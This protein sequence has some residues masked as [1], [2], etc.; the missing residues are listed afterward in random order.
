MSV[1]GFGV[2]TSELE[3]FFTSNG[4]T[5]KS[6]FVGVF[7]ADK[8][9]ENFIKFL[10]DLKGKETR[11]PF[12][13]ASTDPEKKLGV[14]W[15]S[16]LDTEE[17]DTL[18]L[19]DS[20]GSHGLL[21]FIVEN[22]LSTFNKLIPGQF[23]QIFKK[24]NKITLLK[25][26]FIFWKYE[27]HKEKELNKLFDTARHF[28]FGKYKGVKNTVKVVTVDD[29]VQSHDTDYC[30]PFQM[31]FYLNLFEPLE[32]SAVAKSSS[33]K[34]TV[35]LI[36]KLLNETFVN[37]ETRH[38]ERIVDAFILQNNIK[39]ADSSDSEMEED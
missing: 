30:G 29:N 20:F 37:G 36:G 23:K 17:K 38:N 8:K 18:F 13:I 26:S 39:F 11:Y 15:W 19:F 21:H 3:R 27:K 14:H 32:T 4:E 24:D 31:Y 6:Q 12:M 5:M 9:G 28:E 34:L 16:F 10:N 25:W 22:D 1:K 7:P 2:R 35:D 33:K